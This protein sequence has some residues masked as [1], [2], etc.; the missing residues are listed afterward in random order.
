MISSFGS[1][2]QRLSNWR[3]PGAP[4]YYSNATTRCW[5][6]D[7][8][9][10]THSSPH[11]ILPFCLSCCARMIYLNRHSNDFLLN[12]YSRNHVFYVFEIEYSEN[13]FS[14]MLEFDYSEKTFL[15]HTLIRIFK[16][17]DHS[18]PFKYSKKFR[19]H[20]YHVH[21]FHMTSF[22][23]RWN[24]FLSDE[25]VMQQYHCC[26]GWSFTN[27]SPPFWRILN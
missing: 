14:N 3:S 2:P 4:G 19:E 23:L 13:F 21:W 20:D 24:S 17:C 26:Y 16:T 22:W 18:K 27:R 9:S 1:A 7:E 11:E 6:A 15:E 12:E 10:A 8:R 25:V 5:N